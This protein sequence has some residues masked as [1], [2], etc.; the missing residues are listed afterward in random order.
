MT[1]ALF[2]AVAL[3]GVVARAAGESKLRLCTK[4]LN[5]V[6]SIY[7]FEPMLL[8]LSLLW[9]DFFF[10]FCVPGLGMAAIVGSSAVGDKI[11]AV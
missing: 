4:F 9:C 7:E 6:K 11:I 10:V 2:F 1:A 5:D 3:E 8:R